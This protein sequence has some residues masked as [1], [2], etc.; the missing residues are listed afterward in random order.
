MKLSA[1]YLKSSVVVNDMSGWKIII[2][3]LSIILMTACTVTPK[4]FKNV[5]ELAGQSAVSSDDAKAQAVA[6]AAI[7]VPQV[8]VDQKAG[9]SVE[10]VVQAEYFSANGRTCRRYAEFVDGQSVPGVSCRDVNLGWVDIPLS[11]F[12]R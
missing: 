6:N 11:S 8:Y 3:A 1:E 4:Q 9:N 2:P 7:G 12:V 5:P 10:L